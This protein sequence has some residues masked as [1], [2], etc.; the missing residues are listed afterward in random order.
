MSSKLL[1]MHRVV[2]VCLAAQAIAFTGCG[3]AD[4]EARMDLQQKKLKYVE[5][6]NKNLEPYKIQL[7]DRK[8][9][10]SVPKEDLF[11][12]PPKGIDGNGDDKTIGADI[13]HF[14]GKTDGTYKEMWVAAVK[15]DN[16]AKFQKDV[17]EQLKINARAKKPKPVGG[18]GLTQL[19]YDW[20]HDDQGARGTYDAYFLKKAPFLVA[21]VFK[22]ESNKDAANPPPQIDFALASLRLGSE[23]RTQKAG[24]PPASP[25]KATKGAKQ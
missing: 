24:K 8:P 3:L 18:V 11:L 9:D 14:P 2:T 16:E 20:V 4:Y 12:R 6:E 13:V 1:A 23:A 7:S 22:T 25:P 19:T 5:E 15:R 17:L 21:V 10:D